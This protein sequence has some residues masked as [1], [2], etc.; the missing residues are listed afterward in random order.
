[1]FVYPGPR[2]LSAAREGWAAVTAGCVV[3]C[4]LR[5]ATTQSTF[6]R[7]SPCTRSSL[8]RFVRLLDIPSP[9]AIRERDHA[10][11]LAARIA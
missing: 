6:R 5:G 8:G 7:Q 1:M 3:R 9:C 10:T 4:H 2:I 11:D